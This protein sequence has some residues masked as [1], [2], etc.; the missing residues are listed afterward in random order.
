MLLSSVDCCACLKEMQKRGLPTSLIPRGALDSLNPMMKIVNNCAIPFA[1]R[2][3]VQG[4]LDTHPHCAQIG[5]SRDILEAIRAT[6]AG[7]K[8]CV[9]RHGI[10]LN[11]KVIIDEPMA[12]W[13]WWCSVGDRNW[14]RAEGTGRRRDFRWP[15]HG[16][17]GAVCQSYWRDGGKL[18]EVGPVRDIFR[19]HCIPTQLLIGSLPTLQSKEMFEA[20]G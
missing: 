4:R 14:P 19:I 3:T 7:M 8:L 10:L 6:K 15:R 2:L 11:P 17:D 12:P 9:C 18:V 5:G 20:S 1:P 13:V 16:A